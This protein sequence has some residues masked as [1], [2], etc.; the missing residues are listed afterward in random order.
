MKHGEERLPDIPEDKLILLNETAHETLFHAFIQ[1]QV[2]F[3]DD[4]W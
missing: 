1:H 2:H 4:A 3:C